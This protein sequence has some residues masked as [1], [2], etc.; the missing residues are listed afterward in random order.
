ME[1]IVYL[2]NNATTPLEDEVK[3]AIIESLELFGNAS[4]MHQ[5]GMR[6]KDA[7]DKA[8]FTIANFLN[9][10]PDEI[11][12][13]GSGSEANNTVLNTIYCQKPSCNST[14]CNCVAKKNHIIT[15]AFEHPS[16]LE[17]LKVYEQNGFEVTYLP[18]GSSGIVDPADVVK[19]I[20]NNTGLISIMFANNEIGTI[21]P[22]EEIANIA[23]DHDIYMHTDAVQAIGK[24]PIDLQKLP[25]SFLSLSGH[26]LYAPKGIGALYSR[27]GAEFCPLIRGGH[28]EQ[29]RRAGTE[30]TLGIVALGKAIEIT[31]RKMEASNAEMFRLRN[32]LLQ[33]L[34]EKIPHLFV[35]GD[36]HHCLP[37]TL[38]VTFEYI[39]GES[40]LLYADFEGIAVSTGSACS[41][42][43]LDPSHVI[44]ALG[45][46]HEHAH[47]SVRFSLGRQTTEDDI[48]Y[49]LEKFPP[50]IERLRQM[51]PL[52]VK[53]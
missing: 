4:S 24:L 7:I 50:V 47:G 39:E 12:F 46:A 25:V 23:K 52:Y 49:V 48:D 15:S 1:R 35:N 44:L 8:R 31:A 2:D 32:K 26:K 14:T 3:Q 11:I 19:N 28:H 33:G 30:N 16:V 5:S 21:Q 40:I 51:S 10:K 13:T 43:S 27:K 17:T 37:N 42:G 53:L 20:K 41:T 9:C 18:V 29:N 38:N 6:A 34:I 45:V 36:Q 22:I